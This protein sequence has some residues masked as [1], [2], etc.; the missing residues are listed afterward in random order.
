VLHEIQ[1]REHRNLLH[2]NGNTN[3]HRSNVFEDV[4]VCMKNGS[5]TKPAVKDKESKK[6]HGTKETKKVSNALKEGI[7][8][9]LSSSKLLSRWQSR[10]FVLHPR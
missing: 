9:K 8:E 1:F 5:S 2:K 3:C 4:F 10:W 6:S 7:L